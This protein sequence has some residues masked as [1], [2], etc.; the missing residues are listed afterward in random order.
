MKQQAQVS[1]FVIV[2]LLLLLGVIISVTVF[3]DFLSYRPDPTQV[4]SELETELQPL[5]FSVNECQELLLEEASHKILRGG[6]YLDATSAGLQATINPASNSVQ[7]NEDTIIPYWRYSRAGQ[8]LTNKPALNG[9]QQTSIATQLASYV[10]ERLVDCAQLESYSQYDITARSP[11]SIVTFS[12]D[13]TRIDTTWSVTVETAIGVKEYDGFEAEV[14]APVQRLYRLAEQLTDITQSTRLVENRVLDWLAIYEGLNNLPPIS[15]SVELSRN[16]NVYPIRD[17]REEL[18][19]VTA[20]ALTHITLQGSENF[21]L[22]AWEDEGLNQIAVNSIIP[23][24]TYTH[25]DTRFEAYN[26]T[27]N[28]PSTQTYLRINGNR[29]VAMPEVNR[30]GGGIIG[31]VLPPLVDNTFN[32]DVIFP[33]IYELSHNE[34]T[35]QVAYQAAIADNQPAETQD[36]TDFEEVNFCDDRGGERINIRTNPAGIQATA[37]FSCGQITCGLGETHDG[38]LQAEL[39]ACASGELNL[40]TDERYSDTITISSGTDA[41][42]QGPIDVEVDLYEPRSIQVNL[43]ASI[44]RQVGEDY[45]LND[46]TS[47]AEATTFFIRQD[48]PFLGQLETGNGEVDLIPGTYEVIAISLYEGERVIEAETRNIE[49]ETVHLPEVDLSGMPLVYL[50]LQEVVITPNTREVTLR[51]PR[52]D[53]TDL[54]VVEDLDIFAALTDYGSTMGTDGWSTSS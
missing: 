46:A 49:G 36:L 33:V 9:P 54:H 18:D 24:T 37:T 10:D 5:V 42:E 38:R 53:I 6:G 52:V 8:E 28:H 4:T 34:Y 26:P 20:R 11:R 17:A 15:G 32:Y 51:A 25:S 12:N 50:E 23:R 39:P 7:L 30:I 14:D 40:Y 2:G 1:I 29:A 43:Q 44:V 22:R 19:L 45:Q 16:F 35:L 31:A 41:S 47:G 21:R 27:T 3:A 48:A 13:Q